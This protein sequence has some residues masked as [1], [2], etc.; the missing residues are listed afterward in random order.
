MSTSSSAR[1]SRGGTWMGPSALSPGNGGTAAASPPPSTP[2]ILGLAWRGLRQVC[3]GRCRA[4][5]SQFCK[6]RQ[7]PSD[8]VRGVGGAPRQH[9]GGGDARHLRHGR[10]ATGHREVLHSRAGR[11]VLALPGVRIPGKEGGTQVDD[12]GD[13]VQGR[14]RTRRAR[15]QPRGQNVAGRVPRETGEDTR[16]FRATRAS[17]PSPTSPDPTC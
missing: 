4:S 13:E 15:A 6:R 1:I 10:V 14:Q 16:E 5:H 3:R 7:T 12:D 9:D 11:G 8:S 2:A 17:S